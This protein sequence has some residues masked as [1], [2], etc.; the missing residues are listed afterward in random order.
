MPTVTLRPSNLT[1]P[2]GAWVGGGDNYTELRDDNDTT[3]VNETAGGVTY[4]GIVDFDDLPALPAGAKISSVT[5]RVRAKTAGLPAEL[6]FCQRLSGVDGAVDQI[7]LT[8]SPVTYSGSSRT[9]D[10]GGGA[11]STADVDNLQMKFW[12]I[13]ASAYPQYVHEVYLDV[14]YNTSPTATVTGP[15]EGATITATRTPTVTHTITDPEGDA[16]TAWQVKLFTQAQFSAGG[17]DPETSTPAYNSGGL[18]GAGLSHVVTTAMPNGVYR[19]YVKSSDASGYGP[20]L[21]RRRRPSR[22]LAARP[23][24][25]T[26]RPSAP[27]SPPM[28]PAR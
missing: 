27:R 22:P 1:S 11:W 4:H 8:G 16:Q 9:L 28:A 19:A 18:S 5:L 21:P 2:T 23:S 12:K 25:P 10:P 17:F 20:W 24:R 6:Q 7:T 26:F 14:V 3:T 15:A 13:A